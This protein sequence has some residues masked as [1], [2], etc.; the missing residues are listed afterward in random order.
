MAFL[1]LRDKLSR[2]KNC[3]S[4]EPKPS[5]YQVTQKGEGE[6]N[7]SAWRWAGGTV[8]GFHVA[9][10]DERW[11]SEPGQ[12]DA[13]VEPASWLLGKLTVP[14]CASKSGEE[15]KQQNSE[16]SEKLRS[17]I[18]ENSAVK[19]EVEDLHKKLEMA[20]LMIQQVIL[21]ALEGRPLASQ[22]RPSLAEEGF[23]AFSLR[24]D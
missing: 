7:R 23:P 19:L 9:F 2:Q 14:L 20:E 12:G 18:A 21:N 24:L 15:L 11:S 10:W 6:G 8:S 22:P 3:P 4:P 16:L 1:L 13:R 17:L 5:W